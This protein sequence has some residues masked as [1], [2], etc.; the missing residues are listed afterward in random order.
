MLAERV[1]VELDRAAV[2]AANFLLR[3]IDR[4]RRV[5]AALGI[6]EEL[7]EILRATP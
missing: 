3:E 6:V 5:G 2:G 7:G 4:E 1:D